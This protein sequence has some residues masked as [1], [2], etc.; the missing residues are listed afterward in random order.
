MA[1]LLFCYSTKICD[2]MTKDKH[3][4]SQDYLPCLLAGGKVLAICLVQI[5]YLLCPQGHVGYLKHF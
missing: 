3:S 1:L 4:K 2:F 5:A